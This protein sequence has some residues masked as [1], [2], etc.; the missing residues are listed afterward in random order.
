[1]LYVTA[2]RTG[3]SRR[4]PLLTARIFA[5]L[6]AVISAACADQQAVGPEASSRAGPPDITAEIVDAAH[7]AAIDHFYFLPPMVPNPT[8]GGVFDGLLSPEV[9]ICELDT[10]GSAC[11][12]TQPTAFPLVYTMSSGPDSETVTVDPAAEHYQ[13]NWHSKDFALDDQKTYRITVSL[14]SSVLGYA[15]VDVVSSGN[16][17]KNVDTGD[18]IALK[19]GRTLPIKFRI[20]EGAV[21]VCPP[22]DLIHWWPADGNS[23]FDVIGSA[24]LVGFGAATFAAG[25]VG[26]AFATSGSGIFR[27]DPPSQPLYTGDFTLDVWAKPDVAVSS[28]SNFASVFA[29]RDGSS[30]TGGFQIEKC[31]FPTTQ[32]TA[33]YYSLDM[34]VT[35]GTDIDIDI[36]P[37]AADWRH[38]AV[39]YNSTTGEVVTYYQGAPASTATLGGP[40][41]IDLIKVGRNRDG[42]I[43][44]PGSFDELHIFNRVLTASEIQ[45][46]FEADG[47]ACAYQ[48]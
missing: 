1:M 47:A 17:L 42:S 33:D 8:V 35:A 4:N 44:F 45:D 29:S 18:F 23:T 5:L 34:R 39:T 31:G 20:E 32:C 9:S 19:D 46:I 7:S 40:L 30:T 48:P 15:D 10:A 11:A 26:D 41:R 3:R 12:G 22:S 13:V 16:E 14:G 21:V 43:T 24:D 36:G 6:L 38:L 28:I 2:A 27:H 37:I 25:K